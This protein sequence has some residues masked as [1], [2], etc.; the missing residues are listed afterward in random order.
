M[1]VGSAAS[2]V[3]T[4]TNPHLSETLLRLCRTPATSPREESRTHGVGFPAVAD[5]LLSDLAFAQHTRCDARAIFNGRGS[6]SVD[7]YAPLPPER[8]VAS[9]ARCSQNRP[10]ATSIPPSPARGRACAGRPCRAAIVFR[11]HAG[12]MQHCVFPRLRFFF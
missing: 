7:E 6:F 10:H 8:A 5:T 1:V 4:R 3:R 9:R 11:R 12:N 2:T